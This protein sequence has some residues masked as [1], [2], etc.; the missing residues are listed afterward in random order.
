VTTSL[1]NKVEL[2]VVTDDQIEPKTILDTF[3]ETIR[4]YGHR[5]ALIY[6][7]NETWCHLTWNDYYRQ[8]K[9][10]A[11][12]FLSLGL[13]A[14]DGVAIFGFNSYQ[15]FLCNMAAIM[16]G[17]VSVG[18]YTTNSTEICDFIINDSHSTIIIVDDNTY[19]QKIL[20]IPEEHR[21]HIKA[22]IQYH[23]DLLSQEPNIYSWQMFN[24]LSQEAIDAGDRLHPIISQMRPNQ[25]STLIYTSGTTGNPK[26][27]MLSHDN[28]IWTVK[29]VMSTLGISSETPQRVVSYLPLSHIA[30][31]MVDI[32]MPIVN[33]GETWFADSSALRGTLITT[34]KQAEPTIFLGVPRVWEKIMEKMIEKG[35]TLS[36]VKQSISRKVKKIGL[37]Q[38]YRMEQGLQSTNLWWK[39]C[40]H[41]IY[42]KIKNELGLSKCHL[43]LTGAAPIS[44][45]VLEYFASLN[46]PICDIFGMSESSGCIAFSYHSHMRMGTSGVKLANSEIQINPETNEICTRGRHVMMGY[47]DQP[48]KTNEAIDE[49]GWLH[50]GDIGQLD[51]D[52]YLQITGRIKELLITAGG[53]NIPPVI[54]ENNIKSELPVLSNCMVVGDKMKYLTV[55]LTI[56]CQYDDDNYPTD[57]VDNSITSVLSQFGIRTHKISELMTD[58]KFNEYIE[59]GLMRVNQKSIS[60]A[61]RVQKFK[62]LPIDFSM[63]G[64]EI[65]PTLKLKRIV[66]TEKYRSV[67][68]DLYTNE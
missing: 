3:F 40:N 59:S 23:G 61:H 6:K 53:E 58:K 62:I 49:Y 46:I 65:G 2:R 51:P 38:Y 17:G 29:T 22:M 63:I 37:Q 21:R 7:N 44:K 13:Q 31:Q 60:G 15:W 18:I 12:G 11:N 27:V 47:L 33:G 64:G 52:G 32:Y 39:I 20:S 10:L 26:G 50:T 4:R 36:Q 24:K 35:N 66:V 8:A 68:D 25:C 56:K 19:L 48:D 5:N 1:S 41:V 43:F 14:T 34:L 9:I 42:S 54:I 16:A 28:I 55:L 57:V 67:I 30:G 45:E